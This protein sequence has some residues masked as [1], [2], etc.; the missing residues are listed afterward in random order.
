MPRFIPVLI[1][2]LFGAAPLLSASE[3]K[4]RVK[5]LSVENL[6]IDGG[7]A[8]SL[9]VG[10]RLS[11][12][13]SAGATAELEIVYVAEHSASC[14]IL[15]SSG[16]ISAGDVAILVSR[17]APPQTAAPT[18][19]TPLPADTV[20]LPVEKE[21]F[22]PRPPSQLAGSISL[23]FYHY[24][25]NGRAGLDFTQS[26][27]RINLKA[28]R[29]L[30][31][32]LTLSIR[33]RGRY[34][35]RRRSPA[36]EVSRHSWENRLWEFSLSYE[37]NAAP[38]NFA[39]GRILPRRAGSIGYIDGIIIEGRL[40]EN[41]RIGLLGGVYPD[42]LYNNPRASLNRGGG[43]I[44]FTLGDHP[45]LLIDQTIAALGEYHGRTVNRNYLLVQGRIN[46]VSRFGLYH[47]AEIDINNDW[48][49]EKSGK[50]VSL[51]NLYIN[52]FYNLSGS[53]R[54]GMSYDN[55][56]NY[57]S[58]EIRT[59][60]DSLFDDRIRQGAR[61]R[62]DWN[63]LRRFRLGGAFGFN[64][65]SGDRRPTYTYAA[66]ISRH[67]FWRGKLSAAILA[68]GFNGAF[69]KGTN[70]SLRLGFHTARFGQHGITLGRYL[71]KP[72]SGGAYRTNQWG[73]WR[74]DFSFSGNYFV[75]AAF[76]LDDGDDIRGWRAQGELGY[77]FR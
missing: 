68:S 4:F 20:I 13:G 35:N 52:S 14:R 70:Y 72:S 33:S 24:D 66:D 48:R 67:G 16:T 25:D 57:W 6:Y 3:T 74:S 32:E 26:T 47:T 31:E 49:K 30:G 12:K 23:L 75:G 22:S 15:S 7:R 34:D 39:V 73:E 58:Y 41:W 40:K 28:R 2:L 1:I 63:L 10:D 59:L 21:T 56:Q 43:Y 69:E 54:V 62:F 18:V 65:R 42:W 11:V 64:E 46:F 77:R 60:I 45:G 9:S 71:Y 38:F 53:L 5:Y 37:D 29:L 36:P 8:D 51:S 55:R 50:T 19:S 76:Q 27:A 61:A 44:N 17:A